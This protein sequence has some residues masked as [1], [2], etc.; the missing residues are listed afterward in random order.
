MYSLDDIPP[1]YQE[2]KFHL[3]FDIN[4][5]E[6]SCQKARFVAGGHMIETPNTITYAS[7]VS[8]DFVRIVL[9]IAAL[10]GLGIFS[11]DIQNAYL[12]AECLEKIWTCAGPEFGSEFR[13]IMIVRM[14]IYVLKSSG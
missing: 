8:R 10:N 9:T 13:T 6:I 2:I 11:C 12:T 14:T 4:L 1:V 3:I 5:G 7:V